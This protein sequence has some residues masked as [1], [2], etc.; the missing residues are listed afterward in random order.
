[1][2][3]TKPTANTAHE[4]LSRQFRHQ[5]WGPPMSASPTAASTAA[6][7]SGS[8]SLFPPRQRNTQSLAFGMGADK[9]VEL[10]EQF[11]VLASKKYHPPQGMDPAK[12]CSG[13]KGGSGYYPLAFFLWKNFDTCW[14]ERVYALD[15]KALWKKQGPKFRSMLHLM[16]H[17]GGASIPT[18]LWLLE[19]EDQ[20]TV[21][22]SLKAEHLQPDLRTDC[23]LVISKARQSSSFSVELVTKLLQ[24]F[25][26]WDD[27]AKLSVLYQ[28][29]QGGCSDFILDIAVGRLGPKKDKFEMN[30][31]TNIHCDEA[32]GEIERSLI[33][34]DAMAKVY[35]KFLAVIRHLIVSCEAASMCGDGWNRFFRCLSRCGTLQSVA[36]K[37]LPLRDLSRPEAKECLGA[38]RNYL[39]SKP[40]TTK[41]DIR[42]SEGSRFHSMRVDGSIFSEMANSMSANSC[43]GPVI[44]CCTLQLY[45]NVW[46]NAVFF[47]TLVPYVSQIRL[48][49]VNLMDRSCDTQLQPKDGWSQLERILCEV[50]KN[51]KFVAV[52]DIL[53]LKTPTPSSCEHKIVR[54]DL[55]LNTE[56]DFAY[57]NKSYDLTEGFVAALKI[58]S[59]KEFCFRVKYCS[60]RYEIQVE[61]LCQALGSNTSIEKLPLEGLLFR[62]PNPGS[63]PSLIY[64]SIQQN[65]SLRTLSVCGDMRASTLAPNEN[66]DDSSLASNENDD[67]STLDPPENDDGFCLHY[68]DIFAFAK[69][70]Y[71]LSMDPKD[72]C[73]VAANIKNASAFVQI[74]VCTIEHRISTERQ[75]LYGM[76]GL[77]PSLQSTYIEPV[78]LASLFSSLRQNV[79]TWCPAALG[80][81]A[82][83][84][85]SILYELLSDKPHL[86]C[87]PPSSGI[88]SALVERRKRKRGGNL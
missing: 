37:D 46:I 45:R 77:L 85:V 73:T 35:E 34:D 26:I 6:S 36:F 57:C 23:I 40:N 22:N 48:E 4:S 30:L 75:A 24:P 9:A 41:L 17:I 72:L 60:R 81:H 63:I 87:L 88:G 16:C 56:A 76:K 50:P 18:L 8:Q 47:R 29:V 27:A 68:V 13:D 5:S 33:F 52:A 20:C 58:P 69:I 43:P 54:L 38:L 44:N 86:W 84:T 83:D 51:E 12:F 32:T 39:A 14:L 15:P 74:L 59:L 10:L 80:Q 67:S 53:H 3:R 11:P 2:I 82:T 31:A 42:F 25:A 70:Q 7:R 62:H 21:P 1:M 19:K 64:Q 65:T 49:S 79:V 71:V 61:R 66:D 28:L 55:A 78:G